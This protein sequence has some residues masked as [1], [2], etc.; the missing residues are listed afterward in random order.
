MADAELQDNIAPPLAKPAKAPVRRRNRRPI[1]P[2]ERR[3]RDANLALRLERLGADPWTTKVT[4]LVDI[5]SG[6]AFLDVN[7]LIEHWLFAGPAKQRAAAFNLAFSAFH[8]QAGGSGFRAYVLRL[9]LAKAAAGSLGSAI[10]AMAALYGTTMDNAKR[11]GL[12]KPIAV[13]VHPRWDL[14]LGVWD[15]HLHCIA[16]VMPG[17]EDRFFLRLATKFSTP[18]CIS[19]IE[20]MPAWANYSS[21]WIIDHREL[22]K[23]PDSA[24]LEFWNLKAPQLIR[25]AGDFA[26][27]IR[28]NR[29]KS[30]RWEGD[31]VVMVDKEPRQRRQDAR[32][33]PSRGNQQVAYAEVRIGGR[34]RHCAILKHDREDRV[35]IVDPDSTT[36]QDAPSGVRVK[37][38]TTTCPIPSTPVRDHSPR[39]QERRLRRRIARWET[40][41]PWGTPQRPP[42]PI[43]RRLELTGVVKAPTR[44]GRP[45]KLRD[46]P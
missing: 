22:S 24:V 41:W 1:D 26:A 27:F 11:D 42:G 14:K 18:K 30:F 34:R 36:S 44:Q 12:A 15:L 29:D 8:A 3:R 2:P 16:D 23:W 46:R 6:E 20:N 28:N 31:K 25:K 17:M 10:K 40:I 45:V 38:T 13:F 7:P 37:P 35:A 19:D 33:H 4:D 21:A 32:G 9:P 43:R 39:Q 5:E